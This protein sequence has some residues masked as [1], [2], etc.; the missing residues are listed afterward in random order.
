MQFWLQ[1]WLILKLLLHCIKGDFRTL[2]KLEKKFIPNKLHLK[3]YEICIKKDL[4]P[5]YNNI[6][7]YIYI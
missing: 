7:I 3:L 1:S 2:D 4:L 6:Y 5:N